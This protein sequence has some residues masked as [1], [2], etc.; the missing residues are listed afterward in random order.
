MDLRHSLQSRGGYTSTARV[1]NAVCSRA[2]VYTLQ[3]L[4]FSRDL[5]ISCSRPLTTSRLLSSSSHLLS[6]ILVVVGA[7]THDPSA[8]ATLL[9]KHLGDCDGE[10]LRGH[11]CDYTTRPMA[12]MSHS[13]GNGFC[14]AAPLAVARVT[15]CQSG[16]PAAIT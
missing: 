7:D 2:R 14:L 9:A 10:G 13:D 6:C 8:V 1:P 11:A 5:S 12:K 16:P 3:P 4:P 15:P